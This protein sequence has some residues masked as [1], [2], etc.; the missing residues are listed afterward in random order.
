MTAAGVPVARLD[1]DVHGD[2]WLIFE[3]PGCECWHGPRVGR[4]GPDGRPF[5]TWNGDL[6]R[7]TLSPSV[8]VTWTH[9]PQHEPRRCHSFVVD[10][11]IQ[12]L[13]DST[14]HLAG[15]TVPLPPFEEHS[16]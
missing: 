12:F 13:R 5:W 1:P 8:L 16:S 11:S 9:G 14:H 3:C 6:I 15:R 7:P 4:P 2:V 10:G